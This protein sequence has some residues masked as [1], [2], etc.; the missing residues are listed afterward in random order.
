MVFLTIN[1]P[2]FVG[3][4]EF[5]VHL[6]QSHHGLSQIQVIHPHFDGSKFFKQRKPGDNN[7]FG[8]IQDG[9]Q[10]VTLGISLIFT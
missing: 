3:E 6:F 9:K 10:I 8:K 4:Y 5:K 2:P 7:M 1:K